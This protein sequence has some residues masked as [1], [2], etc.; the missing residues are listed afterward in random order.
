MSWDVQV[1]TVELHAWLCS[2]CGE[3]GDPTPTLEAAEAGAAEHRR[4]HDRLWALQNEAW[5]RQL[6]AP[7]R[8]PLDCGCPGDHHG[9]HAV[10]CLPA[11][12][13]R[14]TASLGDGILD[15]L[16]ASEE[17]WEGDVVALAERASGRRFSDP[18]DRE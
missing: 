18:E 14:T 10:V 17:P 9:A 5:E 11:A 3:A 15:R 8:L 16:E 6:P 12:R 13:R 7:E 2:S 1:R 4:D